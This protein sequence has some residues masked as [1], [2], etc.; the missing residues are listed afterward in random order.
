GESFDPTKHQ[1]IQSVE[2]DEVESD[3]I[4][5]VLQ[6]GYILQ[7]RVIRPAMVAVAK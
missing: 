4:A 3:Q 7:D 2:S 6:K 5:Q 1:A